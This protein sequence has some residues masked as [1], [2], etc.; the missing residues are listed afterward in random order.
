MNLKLRLKLS[1]IWKLLI[2]G[3]VVVLCPYNNSI[4]RIQKGK[5]TYVTKQ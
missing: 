1:D 2:G 3:S 4:Y 5:D